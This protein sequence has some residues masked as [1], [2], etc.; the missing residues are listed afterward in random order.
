MNGR[1]WLS[2]LR[3]MVISMTWNAQKRERMARAI[4]IKI[5]TLATMLSF[6]SSS[7]DPRREYPLAPGPLNLGRYPDT[8]RRV[9]RMNKVRCP[10]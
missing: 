10:A 4:V 2:D 6:L 9:L 7:T 5:N 8:N 3:R 1:M